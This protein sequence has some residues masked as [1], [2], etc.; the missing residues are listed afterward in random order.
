M[1]FLFW[2]VSRIFMG[3]VEGLGRLVVRV[4]AGIGVGEDWKMVGMIGM[5]TMVMMVGRGRMADW[6]GCWLL[7]GAW[8]MI[9]GGSFGV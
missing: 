9:L 4:E 5:I 6:M 7:V 3:F 8:S 2:G 1:G